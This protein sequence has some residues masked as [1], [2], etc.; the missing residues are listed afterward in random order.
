MSQVREQSLIDEAISEFKKKDSNIISIFD[1]RMCN[2]CGACYLVCPVEAI[3]YEDGNIEVSE[4]CIFCEKCLNICSQNQE[5]RYSKDFQLRERNDSILKIEPKMNKIPFGEIISLYNCKSGR[6]DRKEF[7]MV[8]GAVTSI[9]ECAIKEGIIDG[10]I[11]IDFSSGRIFPSSVLITNP[12]DLLRVAGSRYLPTYSLYI[13]KELHMMDNISSV[14]I[15]TL[16]CQAYVIDKIRKDNDTKELIK[17]IKVVITL[18]C[19]NGLPSRDEVAE[20]LSKQG[21]NLEN[22]NFKAYREKA[23]SKPYLNPMNKNRYV[24]EENSGKKKSF[25]S[26]RVFH[27]RGEK[28]CGLI[29]PDYTGIASDISVGGSGLSKNIVITRSDEGE[30]LTKLAIDKGYLVKLSKFSKLNRIVVNF[31]GNR[32][33]ENIRKAYKRTFT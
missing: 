9:L 21:L 25:A 24:Y 1:N 22:H 15:V 33:R 19:G 14:A 20:F 6:R 7:A 30:K 16:P 29:C 32:K 4:D 11:T 2:Y 31:M 12:D 26:K 3:S 23:V 10:A 27:T 17:K 13:L 8:G 18:L 28:H 5:H